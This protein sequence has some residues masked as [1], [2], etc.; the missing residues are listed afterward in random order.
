MDKKYCEHC[1]LM[2]GETVERSEKR[3][4]I[5]TMNPIASVVVSVSLT[6]DGYLCQFCE[7][8]TDHSHCFIATTG[9][10]IGL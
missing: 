9:K 4:G 10:P 5:S 3:R 2:N 7:P 6:D 1:G 8:H